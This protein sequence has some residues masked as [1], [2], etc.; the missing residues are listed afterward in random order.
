MD[1]AWRKDIAARR[2]N[3]KRNADTDREGDC[4]TS[5]IDRCNQQKIGHVEDDP[6]GNSPQHML[7]VR[8]QYGGQEWFSRCAQATQRQ[9]KDQRSG[10]Q[11][12]NVVPVEELKAKT[13][14]QLDCVRPRSPAQHRAKH[15]CKRYAV[16]LWLI[17]GYPEDYLLHA[18]A[19][20]EGF[21]ER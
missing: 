9:S 17:H 15:E 4:K 18:I 20:M 8:C 21:R 12:E 13:W 3:D 6:A 11:P 7:C 2:T 16:R 10:K 14:T 19:A 1:S 5:N